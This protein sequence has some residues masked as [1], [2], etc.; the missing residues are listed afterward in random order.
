MLNLTNKGRLSSKDLC[1][2]PPNSPPPLP[3]WPYGSGVHKHISELAPICI[4][5]A[6][7][8]LCVC[9]RMPCICSTLLLCVYTL[10][11]YH[12]LPSCT[13]SELQTEREL[14]EIYNL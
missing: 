14:Q 13:Q 1:R 6:R 5:H 9:I 11:I 3:L 12:D 7:R 4:T 2:V 8:V 10:S